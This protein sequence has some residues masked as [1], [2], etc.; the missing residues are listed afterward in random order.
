MQRVA[1]MA[2]HRCV[3]VMAAAGR[4]TP[5]HSGHGTWPSPPQCGHVTLSRSRSHAILS[6]P[7]GTCA[8]VGAH[9]ASVR[10]IKPPAKKRDRQVMTLLRREAFVCL[11]CQIPSFHPAIQAVLSATMLSGTHSLTVGSPAAAIST[12][13]VTRPDAPACF[14]VEVAVK[15]S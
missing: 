13:H 1:W 6:A 8:I 15:K 12:S 2:A 3:Q 4:S 11:T 10:G 14:L 5:L 9:S 7:P